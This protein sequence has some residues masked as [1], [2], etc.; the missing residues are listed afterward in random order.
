MVQAGVCRLYVVQRQAPPHI[1]PG[2]LGLEREDV[3]QAGRGAE[4]RAVRAAGHKTARRRPTGLKR[5]N[6]GF[7]DGKRLPKKALGLLR[8]ETAAKRYRLTET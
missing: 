7:K 8:E 5:R 1:S 3:S 2:S 6:R 4:A